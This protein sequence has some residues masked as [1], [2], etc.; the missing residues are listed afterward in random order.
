MGIEFLEKKGATIRKSWN[1]GAR[2]LAAPDLFTKHPECVTR[3]VTGE[4]AP[5]AQLKAGERLR[6]EC[7]DQKLLAYRGTTVVVV[8]EHPAPDLLAA[9]HDTGGCAVGK[10]G[11]M[12]KRSNTV[13][14][15][16][17]E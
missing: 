6:L 15:E 10:M 13:E 3:S 11:K 4:P 2:R 16:V 5:G 1:G 8:C 14:I 9:I 7:M 12:R 17:K